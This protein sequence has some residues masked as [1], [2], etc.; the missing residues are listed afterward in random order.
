MTGVRIAVTGTPGVGK[1]SFCSKAKWST[2]S[3]KNLAEKYDCIGSID[4]D[5]SAPI[6]IEKLVVKL[7]WAGDDLQLIDGHLSHLLPVDAVILI[8]CHP[9]TL[10]ERLISRGYSEEKINE[11]IECELIGIISAECQ[12]LPCLELD[13][14][15]GIH[16]MIEQSE[17][18]IADGFKPHRPNEA[19]DWIAEIHGDD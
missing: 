8:R 14:A 10:R 7:N 17:R 19:I 1:T 6:D 2:N 13:S 18:W 3:V 12:K 15:K 9:D 4:R 5:G 16:S 11:N